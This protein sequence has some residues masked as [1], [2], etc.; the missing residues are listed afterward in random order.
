MKIYMFIYVWKNVM[1][2]QMLEMSPLRVGTVLRFGRDA[3]PNGYG[4][5]QV[6]TPSPPF[7]P[8]VPF[9][10]YPAAVLREAQASRH[11]GCSKPA[12]RGAELHPTA[13]VREGGSA[14][15]VLFHAQE[16]GGCRRQVHQ[17]GAG[18]VS[19]SLGS[20]FT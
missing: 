13:F 20:A 6:K 3:W 4:K 19:C 14:K 7:S 15:A 2:A 1:S 18:L 9:R 12:V 5:Q 17:V 11:D 10:R 16:G 8:R